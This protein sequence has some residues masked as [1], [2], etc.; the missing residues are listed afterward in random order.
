MCIQLAVMLLVTVVGRRARGQTAVKASHNIEEVPYEECQT[1]RAS[2][3]LGR[4]VVFFLMNTILSVK[5][6]ESYD[7]R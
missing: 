7:E 1:V 4:G 2:V 5:R 3:G 6:R